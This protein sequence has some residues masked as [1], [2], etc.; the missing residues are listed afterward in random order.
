MTQRPTKAIQACEIVP[1]ESPA[2]AE[3]IEEN[4][5]PGISFEKTVCDLSDVGRGMK[6]SCEFKFT[7]TGRGLPKK[8][9]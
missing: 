9:L 4:H 2:K 6:N 5:S 7:N 8:T 1:K 3:S